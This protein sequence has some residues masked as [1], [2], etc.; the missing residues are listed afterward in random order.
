MQ[1]CLSNDKTI[2]KDFQWKVNYQLN[3]ANKIRLH[4]PER[5]QGPQRRGATSTTAVEATTQQFSDTPWG[6]AAADAPDPRTR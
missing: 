6:F 2:I 3:S 4:V 5:R 1:K